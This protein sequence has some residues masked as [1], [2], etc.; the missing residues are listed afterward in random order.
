[1]SL[2]FILSLNLIPV[3]LTFCW[4][5]VFIKSIGLINSALVKSTFCWNVV[6]VNMIFFM[7]Y[8]FLKLHVLSKTTSIKDIENIP[9]KD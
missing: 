4:N 7:L 8:T 5:V 6:L 9:D 2:N 3:K 1:M